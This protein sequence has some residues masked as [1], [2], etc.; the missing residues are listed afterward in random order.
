M[1]TRPTSPAEVDFNLVEVWLRWSPRRLLAGALAGL[2]AG[3]VYLAVSGLLFRAQGLGFWMSFKVSALPCLGSSATEFGFNL[4]P[5]LV[6]FFVTELL[7]AFLGMIYAQMTGL[8]ELPVLVGAGF[9]WGIFSW[10]FIT[11]LFTQ[12]FTDVFAA[13]LPSGRL[14]FAD[15]AF[16]FSLVSVKVFDGLLGGRR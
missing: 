13:Q 11:N 9:V 15:L 7:C 3:L 14:I 6:G 2:F 8:N 16:G 5:I 1:S 4:R 12:S 10:I